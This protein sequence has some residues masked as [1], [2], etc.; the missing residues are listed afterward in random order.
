MTGRTT[1]P[2]RI[3]IRTRLTLWYLA[4]FLVTGGVMLTMVYLLTR[5]AL[6]S[7]DQAVVGTYD[8]V[9]APG[10]SPPAPFSTSATSPMAALP[11]VEPSVVRAY[12]RPDLVEAVTTARR[13]SLRTIV[14]Q[15]GI[16]F[17]AMTMLTLGLGWLVASRA[18]RPLRTMTQVIERLSHDTLDARIPHAGPRDEIRILTD[19]FNTMLDRLSTAFQAQQLFAANASHELRT[20]LT[21][22]QTAA[23]KALSRPTRAEA[24]YRDALTTVVAATH[25][26][27]R[28]LAGLLTLAQLRR[29]VRQDLL[30]LADVVR[31]ASQA[32]PRPGP[33]L[34]VA[35]APA[36]INADPILIQL[37]VR[38]LLENAARYNTDN[39]SIWVSTTVAGPSATLIVA[40][41]GPRVAE[42]DLPKLRRAFQRGSNRTGSHDGSGLGLAIVDAIVEA[43]GAR[44]SAV[45][46]AGGGLTVTVTFAAASYR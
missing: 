9:M 24:E 4:L 10:P 44:W 5:Q 28:I 19:S 17:A 33:A 23:E 46:R 43:H 38:N 35:A 41:T 40:N 21:I 39:G 32:L 22:I 2:R 11:S 37:L 34:Q 6:D 20:P 1:F 13:D 42:V 15:T 12:G 8:A 3:T 18:L 16:L 26:S 14:T 27:E 30:D 7:A 25:R 36:P 29:Q 31:E 45:P